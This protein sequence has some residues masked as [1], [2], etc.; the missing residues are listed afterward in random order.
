M[1]LI[2]TQI[3]LTHVQ[4][5]LSFHASNQAN[6]IAEQFTT[7]ASTIGTT[8]ET[9]VL[10]DIITPK[11][12][13]IKL[14]SGASLLIGLDGTNYPFRLVAANE[15]MLLRLN[16]EGLCQISNVIT[17]ADSSGSLHLKYF[18]VTGASGSW[19]VWYDIDNSGNA[20]PSHEKTNSLGITSVTSLASAVLVASATAEAL[21]A[22]T[23]FSAD[24]TIS[25]TSG[26]DTI[27]LTDNYTGTR[28]SIAANDSDFTCNVLH[29][30][31]AS[32]VIHLKSL[33]VSQ[34]VTAV[35]PN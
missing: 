10:G 6:S 20:A 34:V 32:P 1:S 29:A 5:N 17:I 33:G 14:I 7:L 12:V 18:S 23:A 30:G 8:D 2:Q 4:A 26:T 13:A 27:I 3:S 9:V 31:S 22:S 15:S 19:G 28:A 11:L 35:V 24:F 16:V 21:A 25:Y